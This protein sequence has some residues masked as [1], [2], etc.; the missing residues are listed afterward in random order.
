[1]INIEDTCNQ[2]CN[3]T[4]A[5]KLLDAVS[6]KNM[7]EIASRLARYLLDV[8]AVN[9]VWYCSKPHSA[10]ESIL[11]FLPYL[12]EELIRQL[13]TR[14]LDLDIDWMIGNAENDFVDKLLSY[15]ESHQ[16]LD[17]R[18]MWINKT[19]SM[20]RKETQDDA[21]L[22]YGL[23]SANII[24]S[25]FK[26]TPLQLA[27]AKGYIGVNGRGFLLAV[28]NFQLAEKLLRLGANTAI[29]YQEPTKGN[30]ALHIA[31]ARRDYKAIALLEA[32]GASQTIVNKEGATPADMLSLTF[33]EAEK[34]LVFHT[35]P[36]GRFH[37]FRLDKDEF[38]DQQN[39]SAIEVRISVEHKIRIKEPASAIYI[40][41][42]LLALRFNQALGSILLS[43]CSKK[44]PWADYYRKIE[45][46]YNQ[47]GG[48]LNSYLPRLS[49]HITETQ[50]MALLTS[51]EENK[52][53]YE[54]ELLNG[55]ITRE[56]ANKIKLYEV[57]PKTIW[58]KI[59]TFFQ[60]R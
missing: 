36:K 18:L 17:Q 40:E 28:S 9:T 49:N 58:E 21:K 4:L 45:T 31:Y 7:I 55:E 8:N 52:K 20:L 5:Y 19:D 39:L 22:C 10:Q 50:Y 41:R 12:D 1:M 29:D 34:L 51:I 13:L 38:E 14:G 16:T 27:I 54:N 56:I 26:Q 53:A 60:P 2:I 48:A 46:A 35:S 37:T 11:S 42:Q 30:T 44:I 24:I 6:Y 59:T 57:P 15:V 43:L 25:E 33:S 3:D 23:F 32:Y 47:A